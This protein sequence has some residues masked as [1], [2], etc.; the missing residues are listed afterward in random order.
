[1]DIREQFITLQ[2]LARTEPMAR[3]NADHVIPDRTDSWPITS[4]EASSF[5]PRRWGERS[6]EGTELWL[7]STITR[8]VLPSAMIQI[9][10]KRRLE[11]TKRIEQTKRVVGSHHVIELITFQKITVTLKLN[12]LNSSKS[13]HNIHVVYSIPQVCIAKTLHILKLI[14]GNSYRY[15]NTPPFLRKTLY[16]YKLFEV[17]V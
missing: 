15:A 16:W 1:M 13:L 8:I 4:W 9:L 12:R 5:W 7:T 11:Q 14:P 6:L 10:M 3:S 2:L 17:H